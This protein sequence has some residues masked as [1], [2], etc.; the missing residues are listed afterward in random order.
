MEPYT[1]LVMRGPVEAE[2]GKE[3]AS[4]SAKTGNESTVDAN[5]S[6]VLDFDAYGAKE[7]KK[8]KLMTK[9]LEALRLSFYQVERESTPVHWSNEANV[10]ALPDQNGYS[11]VPSP[12]RF[13]HGRRRRGRGGRGIRG[14][15]RA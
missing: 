2:K 13:C 9:K 8:V 12:A 7:Y 15:R 10:L 6:T 4:E 5:L 1:V 14:R 11:R 3:S